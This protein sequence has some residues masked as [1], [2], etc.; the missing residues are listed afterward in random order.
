M[1]LDLKIRPINIKAQKINGLLF[2]LF[3]MVLISFQV[4]NKLKKP[5]FFKK[6]FLLANFSIKMILRILFLTLNNINI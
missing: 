1:K 4:K 3:K 6:T 5:R 2:K